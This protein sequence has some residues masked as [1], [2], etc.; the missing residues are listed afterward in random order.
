MKGK[1]KTQDDQ[2]R[3]GGYSLGKR[4]ARLELS[5]NSRDEEKEERGK[6]NEYIRLG[7]LDD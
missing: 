4:Q 2:S 5:S 1:K 6:D 3:G 7:R